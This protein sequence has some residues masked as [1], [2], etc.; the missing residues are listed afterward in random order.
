[1]DS[2]RNQPDGTSVYYQSGA[3]EPSKV[4]IDYRKIVGMG[5]VAHIYTGKFNGEDC[6]IKIF[7]SGVIEKK[8]LGAIA[9]IIHDHP[10]VLLVHGLLYS[11]PTNWLPNNDPALVMEL[12]DMSLD[13]FLK[14]KVA[15]SGSALF[16]IVERLDILSGVVSGMT[17]LHSKEIVH[18]GLRA[19][20]VFLK[21]TGPSS[22]KKIL[23][24]VAGV[25]EMKLFTPDALLK[26]RASVQRSGIMPPEVM[27]SGE[28]AELTKA[29][30]LFS[31]GCLI[32]YVASCVPPVPSKQSTYACVGTH[33][34]VCMHVCDL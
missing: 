33:L 26:H 11:N 25:C 9:S 28:D 27:D 22:D 19:Q 17:Y 6:A 8:A 34:S 29:V 10:N 1:M 13:A 30:D 5:S 18:G 4:S 2:S 16:R 31:F 3:L 23:A 12:C 15:R 32:A 20:K 14:R 7:N 21:F 24:K